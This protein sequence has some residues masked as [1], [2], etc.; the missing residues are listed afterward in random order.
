MFSQQSHIAEA[1]KKRPNLAFGNVDDDGGKSH[2]Y[3]CISTYV[4]V[5]LIL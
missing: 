2:K 4:Y 5:K 1:H 3:T